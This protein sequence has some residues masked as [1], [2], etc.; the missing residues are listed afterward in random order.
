MSTWPLVDEPPPPR[1]LGAEA[2]AGGGYEA[3]EWRGAILQLLVVRSGVAVGAA[4][5]RAEDSVVI[6]AMTLELRKLSTD[7]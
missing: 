4:P 6:V 5:G 1:R 7:T 3:G 2:G